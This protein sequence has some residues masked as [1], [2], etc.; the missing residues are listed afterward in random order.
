MGGTLKFSL[1]STDPGLRKEL[2]ASYST[3]DQFTWTRARIKQAIKN[4][5]SIGGELIL[6]G[7][8]DAQSAGGGV[9]LEWIGKSGGVA[10]KVGYKKSTNDENTPY[11]GAEAFIPF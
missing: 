4:N 3:T 1:Y 6:M 8:E 5:V 7:N 10:I 2:L 11:G 9:L